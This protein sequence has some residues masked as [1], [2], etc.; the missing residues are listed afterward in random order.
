[1]SRNTTL[2]GALAELEQGLHSFG[3]RQAARLSRVL[4][5]VARSRFPD[6]RSLI[7]FHEALLFCRAYPQTPELARQADEILG[8]FD[9]LV[10]R[11]PA[12]TP[13]LSLLEEPEASGVAGTGFTAIFSYEVVRRLAALRQGEIAIDWDAYEMSDQMAGL[14]RRLFPL[15]EED[16]L[17]EPRTDYRAWLRAAAGPSEKDLPFLLDRLEQ[18]PAL[19]AD[20]ADLYAS[21][22]LPV[23]WKLARSQASRT[24]MRLPTSE[25]FCHEGPLIA[26]NEVRL[27]TELRSA[28][29]EVER[30]SPQGGQALLDAALTASAVRHRELHGFSHGDPR[31][32]L[33]A[34]AGRG[35]EFYICGV[36]PENRLPLRAYHAAFILKN[37][38]PA[39][40]FETLSFA[41]FVEAG[42]NLYY[43]FREG[44]TAWIFARLLRLFQQVLGG[45]CFS[46]DP[47]QIGLGNPEAVESGAFWFYRKLGFRPVRPEVARL[48][49]REERRLLRKPGYRSSA[50]ILQKL[51]AGR[52]IFEMP[53]SQSGEWDFFSARR[54]AMAAQKLGPRKAASVSKTL[55]IRSGLHAGRPRLAALL[56][57]IPG[58]PRWPQRDKTALAAA[59]RA[60][61]SGDEAVYL[62]LTQRHRR[63]REAIR[64]LGGQPST[65]AA[66]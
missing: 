42:F 53:D 55:G 14:W 52:L 44:E 20:R 38:V 66:G 51:A 35:V 65:E 9:G 10:A 16:F 36:P 61:T 62:Q 41:E 25:V 19:P 22:A 21:L 48:A 24:L 15:S 34:R 12:K 47:Y 63:L 49:A 6:A 2:Q 13:G 29:L 40:Y 7:R 46:I 3:S 28:P 54:A 1:M 39:G 64:K 43:A 45:T 60:K 4:A 50:R 11:L 26:R 17:V 18:M 58:L 30:L 5:R 56:A 59:V 57:A 8:D 32:V 37:G 27:E 33:R 23:R 31:S